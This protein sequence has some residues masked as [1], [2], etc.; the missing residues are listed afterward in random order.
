[1][2]RS[3]ELPYRH[4]LFACDGNTCRSPLAEYM[5]RKMLCDHGVNGQVSVSSGGIAPHARD[6]S[7]IS[8]DMRMIMKD[9]EIP[10]DDDARSQDIKRH[11]EVVEAADLILTMTQLQKERVQKLDNAQGKQIQ[12]LREFIGESGDITDPEGEGE[13]AYLDCKREIE[14]CLIKAVAGPLFASPHDRTL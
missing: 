8:L 6:G 12:T 9:A 1:M 4:I 5:L 11:T 7:L 14:R 2:E 10:F 13:Q 3:K